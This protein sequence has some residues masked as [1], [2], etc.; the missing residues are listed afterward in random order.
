[1]SPPEQLQSSAYEWL[2]CSPGRGER[3]ETVMWGTEKAEASIWDVLVGL[4]LWL[5]SPL[6]PIS[7]FPD[8][9]LVW[10]TEKPQV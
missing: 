5:T 10:L 9:S 4:E 8:K 3:R 7:P 1:M 6:L 2:G